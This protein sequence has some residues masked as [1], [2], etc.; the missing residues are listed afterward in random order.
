MAWRTEKIDGG[1][2]LV[3]D[4]VEQGIA[5]SPTRGTANIQNANIATETGEVMV[6][7]AR[8][9][10]EFAQATITNGTLTASVGDGALYLGT[11]AALESGQWI[12][13]TAVSGISLTSTVVDYAIV[14]GGGGGG[15]GN[16]SYG[17]GGGGAGAI[18]EG[19]LALG[20]GA[21]TITIGAGGAAGSAGTAGTN[22]SSTS[23][24]S[25]I[26]AVGG[27]GGGGQDSKAGKNG[28]SG[29]GGCRGPADGGTKGLGITTPPLGHDG[30]NGF[31]AQGGGGGG[32]GADGSTPGGTAG[33]NGGDGAAVA[34]VGGGTYGGGGGG[35]C[36]GAGTPGTG[37]TGGGGAGGAG[38]GVGT[39]GTANTGGGGGGGGSSAAGGAGG[40]GRVIITY[41][42]GTVTATGGTITTSGSTT[43]HTFTSNGTFTITAIPL[44]TGYY[45]VS[46]V[47]GSG[48]V[49]ISS[50]FDPAADFVIEHGTSGTATFS[51]VH[52]AP[53]TVFIAK[54]TE[55]YQ[56][57]TSTEYRYYMLDADGYV[58]C[59]DTQAVDLK[60]MLTDPT[61]YS[62]YDFTGMAILNGWLLVIN[63]ANIYGKPTVNLGP[64]FTI[65]DNS[66]L[67]N[68]FATHT[69]FAMTGHQGKMFYCD[70]NYVGEL[71]PTTSLVTSVAN[72]QSYARYSATT[73]TLT[74][75]GTIIAGATN[76]TLTTAWTAGVAG[77]VY[78][79]IFSTGE[80]RDVTLGS[81]KTSISWT[82]ALIVAASA[83]ILVVSIATVEE[84]FSGS[85][86]YTLDTAAAIV[87][88]PAVFFAEEGGTLPTEITAET[89][90]YIERTLPGKTFTVYD[91]LTGGSIIDMVSGATG[92]QYFNTFYPI[93]DDAGI[94]GTNALVQYSPQR[95]NLPQFEVAQCMVEVG[96]TVIV[97]GITNTLYPWNQIDA[98]P[99]DLIA[100]PEAN[101]KVMIN[102]NN[103][104]YVFAG[105][106]GN[107]YITNNSVAS[108]VTK[109]PDYCA[110]VPG[111]PLTYIEPYFT[112]GDAMYTRGRV[113]FSILDQ[114]STKAGNCGGIWSFIPTQNFYVGQD[115][116]I[117]LRLENRNSYGSYNGVANVLLPSEEQDAVAPQ[118][119]S[120]WQS[121]YSVGASTFG[122]DATGTV[123]ATLAVVETDLLPTGTLLNKQTFSQLEYKLTAALASGDSVQLYYRL[124]ST[125]AWTSCG[126]EKSETAEPISGYYDINFQKTQWVQI[127][128]ELT[129]NGTATSSFVRFKEIRLR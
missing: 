19:E 121:S 27:G 43:I 129:S 56:T 79:M 84:L 22:G 68:P 75:T 15:A 74:A 26:V 39:A 73:T 3:W 36:Q 110:G 34:I 62:S 28:A 114:L 30:A 66:D 98:T 109:V 10:Q 65:L 127:R 122:I 82:G 47:N 118:F 44:P 7:F 69:N 112:W 21:T 108:L 105:N 76:A 119:W 91:A 85:M 9:L 70:G 33:G 128:A 38:A 88:I 35:G 24:G 96:N 41:P 50:T 99:S 4:G 126:T 123:P 40:S 31:N 5:P 13:I 6:S 45:F 2:D 111:T 60:W 97:G 54:A 46:Q 117:A 102:V 14:G 92:N 100:L 52:T 80:E 72:I 49:T 71:F 16:G 25:S 113:Y 103:M 78:R 94:Y 95:L 81:D 90:Y 89:V 101:V 87:R 115:V 55:K 124:N 11:S 107:V 23:I 104:A 37:G 125:N 93:G 18:F 8:D 63:N 86:P 77:E 83:T 20:I 17:G 12:N 57:D 106:K 48:D 42:T 32:F 116:G 58:W 51:T 120:A 59:Y 64:T 67:N 61:D 1:R 29:G 53:T